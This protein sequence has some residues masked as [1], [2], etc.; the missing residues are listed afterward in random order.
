MSLPAG[1]LPRARTVDWL[2]YVS[3]T[4]SQTG[5]GKR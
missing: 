4:K 5:S 1:I 3:T 2:G